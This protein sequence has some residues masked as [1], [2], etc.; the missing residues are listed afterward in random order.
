MVRGRRSCSTHVPR[1]N[2]IV[3][4]PVAVQ[5]L[6]IETPETKREVRSDPVICSTLQPPQADCLILHVSLCLLE[7]DDVS[8]YTDIGRAP[9]PGGSRP[10][11]R[12]TVRR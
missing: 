2:T 7:T 3:V 9:V 12:A 5:M 6:S 4:H 11:L 10:R 8:R 1:P